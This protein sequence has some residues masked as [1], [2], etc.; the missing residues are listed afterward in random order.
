MPVEIRELVIKTT[1]DNS[2][3][4]SS[5]LPVN[6]KQLKKLLKNLKEEVLKECLLEIDKQFERKNQR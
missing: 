3:G 4:D 2:G 1:I 6:D 5:G